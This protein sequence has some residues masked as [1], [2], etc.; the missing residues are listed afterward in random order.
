ML[1]K[2]L[3]STFGQAW[4]RM[5]IVKSLGKDFVEGVIDW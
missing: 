4:R 2:I 3:T 5:Q 1:L